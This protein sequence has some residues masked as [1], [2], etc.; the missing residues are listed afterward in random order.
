[1]ERMRSCEIPL[2]CIDLN[3]A[4]VTHL[5]NKQTKNKTLCAEKNPLQVSCEGWTAPQ[6]LRGLE[7]GTGFQWPSGMG[8]AGD[9]SL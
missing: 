3:H 8:W 4:C 5:K 2:K 1:M 7:Y 6:V 9:T